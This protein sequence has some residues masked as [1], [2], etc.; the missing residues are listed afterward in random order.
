MMSELNNFLQLHA[1]WIE[2]GHS[3]GTRANFRLT[4]HDESYFTNDNRQIVIPTLDS[5]RLPNFLAAI[6]RRGLAHTDLR[7]ALLEHANLEGVDLRGARLS[8]A[9]CMAVILHRAFLEKADLS[10]ADLHNGSLT[11]ADLKGAKL[12]R[13]DLRSANLQGADLSNAVLHSAKMDSADLSRANLSGADLTS[14]SLKEVILRDAD[15]SGAI[16]SGAIIERALMS[17]ARFVKT[18]ISDTI[19]QRA[20]LSQADF[21][22]ACAARADFSLCN[23]NSACFQ[24]IQ[25]PN[26]NF[27]LVRA[28]NADFTG[29]ILSSTIFRGSSL[30]G[31]NF[32]NTCL[33]FADFRKE[34]IIVPKSKDKPEEQKDKPEEHF[35][36]TNL[37][38]VKWNKADISWARFDMQSFAQL[39]P[40]IKHEFDNRLNLEGIKMSTTRVFICHA[41]EDTQIALDI[42]DRLVSEGFHAWID[43]RN[44]LPGQDWQREIPLIIRAADAVIVCLSRIAVDKRGYIQKEFRLALDE[45][46]KIPPDKIYILPVRL[47]D[48]KVPPEFEGIQYV[49]IWK[50]ESLDNVVRSLRTI[51]HNLGKTVPES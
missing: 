8:G 23:L 34:R 27:A 6:R 48:I 28:D 12:V 25:A 47:D 14:A 44:L 49:D 30:K 40:D 38:D 45:L 35:V 33:H 20:D 26:S 16:L 36:I 31:A 29:A 4:A 1:H 19:L 3:S 37:S 5:A 50:K 15:L 39:P 46:Q 41:H 24:Q 9:A 21:S 18:N 43:Q 51:H 10:D 42:Y 32:N 11:E 22:S 7:Q 2:T 13:A 17:R